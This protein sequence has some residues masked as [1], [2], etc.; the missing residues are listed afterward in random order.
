MNNLIILKKRILNQL[1]FYKKIIRLE[2]KKANI[3]IKNIT[4]KFN[5]E[6]FLSIF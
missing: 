4:N 1:S 2:D 5:R 3:I 6:L